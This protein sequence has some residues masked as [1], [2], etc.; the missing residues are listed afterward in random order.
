[1]KRNRAYIYTD[2]G[3]MAAWQTRR[4]AVVKPSQGLRRWLFPFFAAQSRSLHV[5]LGSKF[6][7]KHHN[8]QPENPIYLMA[9]ST[10]SSTEQIL[11][12]GAV[13][14]YMVCANIRCCKYLISMSTTTQVSITPEISGRQRDGDNNY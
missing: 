11:E 9:P 2:W 10:S 1:M 5:L 13:L 12:R 8:Y 7:P 4:Y 14:L 6:P 3:I